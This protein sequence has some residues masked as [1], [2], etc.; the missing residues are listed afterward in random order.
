[1]RILPLLVKIV[2]VC[3]LAL[4][5]AYAAEPAAAQNGKP[6]VRPADAVDRDAVCTRC[7]DETE[8]KPLLS[9]YQTPHGNKADARTPSC[10][11]CHG[12]S[13]AHLKGDP[14]QRG[15]AAPDIVFGAKSK[16]YPQT[17]AETQDGQCLTCHQS[18]LRTHWSGS[19]HQ[20]QGVPCSSC[21][22][23]HVPK[24]PVLERS[25]QPEVC[26]T[27]HKTQ[28]SEI[29]LFS[30]HPILAGKTACAECHN[31]HGSTGPKMLVKTSTNETCYTC[32]AEKRGP[33][34][35]EHSPVFDDCANCHTPHGSNN[36]P[37]LKQRVPWLCQECHTADHAN[38]VNSGA[39]LLGGDVTTVDG[40]QALANRAPRAQA[41][42]LACLSCHSMIHGSNHPAGA[43]FNR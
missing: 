19:Q 40:Q 38:T 39:N 1:M 24:D 31:P 36:P 12:E 29:H 41:N 5:S 8:T 33:F 25:S 35:W 30:T 2:L 6:A 4:S 16:S 17:P 10:Q 27:C 26:F 3:G 43:K 34:L 21:H 7:H 22:T 13:E 15:R 20:S 28:R 9:I 32:H 18:G 23:S 11:S 14:S 42:G 37:L